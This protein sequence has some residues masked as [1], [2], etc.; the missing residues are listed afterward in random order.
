MEIRE[1]T[2]YTQEQLIE[3]NGLLAQLSEG[4]ILRE[5]DLKSLVESN[6]SHLYAAF[7]DEGR[8]V[9]C[10]TLCL[11]ETL[12]GR[13]GSVE[14]VVVDSSFRGEHIGRR[15]IEHIISEAGKSAPVRIHLTSSPKRIAANGLYRASGFKLKDT[16]FYFMSIE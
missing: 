13:M 5:S 8:I 1:L 11:M 3:L 12:E 7:S 9:G 10:A 15:L 4:L 16:N 6:G 2:T 14:D